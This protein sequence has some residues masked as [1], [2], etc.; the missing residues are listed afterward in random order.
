MPFPRTVRDDALV[1]SRRR[2]CVCQEFGGRSVNVHHIIQEADGGPNTIENAICLCLRC[3]AEAG[4]FNARHPMG[5]KYSPQELRAHR[6]QW[7]MH[8]QSHPEEPVGLFLD[9]R[10]RAASRTADVHRY[11]LLVSYTNSLSEAHYGWKVQIYIPAF[12][13]AEAGD[14]DRDEVEVNGVSYSEFESHSH[15]RV[16]PGET[17][18]VV[19]NSR[20]FFIEYEMNHD[21][22]HRAQQQGNVM[23]KF[24]TS[25]APAIE[26][27]RPLAEL[28]EF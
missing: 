4:H 24:Y 9:V 21:I 19:P 20:Y 2:C 27:E 13:P 22:Y 12:V 16:Y 18:T 7:W 8:C 10:F 5:T 1:R 3:H 11:R 17:I 25:N 23:W 14:F 26:G 28:Q 15:E 6:D